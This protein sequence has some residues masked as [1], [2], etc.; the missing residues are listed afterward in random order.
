M[1]YLARVVQAVADAQHAQ[2]AQKKWAA[3]GTLTFQ[4]ALNKWQNCRN[5]HGIQHNSCG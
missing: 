5:T 2:H 3:M 4:M 1:H